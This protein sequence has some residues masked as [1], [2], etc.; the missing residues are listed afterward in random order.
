MNL[1]TTNWELSVNMITC[2]ILANGMK[3]YCTWR[4]CI[5]FL[6]SLQNGVQLWPAILHGRLNPLNHIIGSS[7]NEPHTSVGYG[8]RGLTNWPTVSVPVTWYGY[9]AHDHA[10]TSRLRSCVW[11]WTLQCETENADDGQAKSRGDTSA[12]NCK[13]GMRERPANLFILV[14]T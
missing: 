7:L 11:W 6:F 5:Q 14:L 4:V 9:G 10:T 12:M 2:W 3:G 8:T 1:L 13:A